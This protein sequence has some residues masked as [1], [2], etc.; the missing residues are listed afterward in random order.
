MPAAPFVLLFGSSSSVRP[1]MVGLVGAGLCK[2]IHDA[3]IFASLYDVVSVADRGAA[4]GRM[5]TVGWTGGLVA[6]IAVGF[7]CESFGLGA[8][9]A[10]TAIVYLLVDALAFIAARVADARRKRVV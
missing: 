2:E 3:N 5:N 4:A 9:V 8:A 7:A 10:S 6:P 1:L